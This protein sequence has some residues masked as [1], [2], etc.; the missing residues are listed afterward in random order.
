MRDSNYIINAQ[1]QLRGRVDTKE[2]Q[3]DV[4][5][6]LQAVSYT[7]VITSRVANLAICMPSHDHLCSSALEVITPN[8]LEKGRNRG[9]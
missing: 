4:I 3:L 7:P 5:Y 1:V 6:T 8:V 2:T 9:P